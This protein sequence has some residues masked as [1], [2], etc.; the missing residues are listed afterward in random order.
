M[1]EKPNDHHDDPTS[2]QIEQASNA[3]TKEVQDGGKK[4]Y[5]EGE[6]KLEMKDL[7]KESS[8]KFAPKTIM[9]K[10][11]YTESET[12]KS[13]ESEKF[14]FA[15]VVRVGQRKQGKTRVHHEGRLLPSIKECVPVGPCSS[16]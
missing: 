13:Q 14:K 10:R 2:E 6:G 15:I 16:D 3:N 4:D 8:D 12:N 9:K 5:E 1:I 11:E 7:V